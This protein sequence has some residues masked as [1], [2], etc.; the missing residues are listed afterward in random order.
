MVTASANHRQIRRGE[1]V[2]ICKL[3]P[4]YMKMVLTVRDVRG[5]TVRGATELLIGFELSHQWVAD[6]QYS[7]SRRRTAKLKRDST[8]S[9]GRS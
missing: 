3:A 7:N 2:S 5:C 9:A 1:R 4:K 8:T 6:N